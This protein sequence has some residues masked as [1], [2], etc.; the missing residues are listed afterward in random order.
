[1]DYRN[2][3]PSIAAREADWRVILITSSD[4]I[5]PSAEPIGPHQALNSTDLIGN[6]TNNWKTLGLHMHTLKSLN[7]KL[8]IRT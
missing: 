8:H 5:G 1:M 7:N 3:W 2:P 6:G 4:L